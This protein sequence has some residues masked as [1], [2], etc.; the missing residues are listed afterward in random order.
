MCL[1]QGPQHSDAGE[2][3]TRSPW[4]SSQATALTKG[5]LGWSAVCN[6][7]ITKKHAFTF[8]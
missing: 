4:A 5:A 7:G 1:A 3:Q 6:C 2:A 8:W